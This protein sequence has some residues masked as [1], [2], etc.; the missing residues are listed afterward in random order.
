[1]K[2]LLC[3][4]LSALTVSA[5]T[6]EW[7][8]LPGAAYYIAW[9]QSSNGPVQIG[10]VTNATSLTVTNSRKDVLGVSAVG[11][12]GFE[13]TITWGT[14]PPPSGIRIRLTMQSADSPTGPW[15]DETNTVLVAS[16]PETGFVRGKLEIQQP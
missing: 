3:V 7:D 15:R 2:A 10:A 4:L 9:F 11:T 6:L 13:S 1:M 14:Q 8:A 5:A 16:L 12:N